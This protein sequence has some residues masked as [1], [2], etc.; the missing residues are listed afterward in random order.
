[1][2][3]Q[4]M[5]W[6]CLLVFLGSPVYA[7]SLCTDCL[8]AALEALTKCLENAISQEDK[9]SCTEKQEAR[10]KSCSNGECKI[11]RETAPKVVAPEKK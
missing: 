6:V 8:R 11:E 1:M 7:Q 5:V 10:S 9:L 2:K 4:G 3:R